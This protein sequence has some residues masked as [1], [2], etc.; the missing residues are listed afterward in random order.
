M[1]R[2][3][4]LRQVTITL[5]RKAN[6]WARE[7]AV[8]LVQMAF[9]FYDI[10]IRMEGPTYVVILSIMYVGGGSVNLMRERHECSSIL[11]YIRL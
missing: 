4:S 6:I 11:W 7:S 1:L 5:L 2:G 10:P 9:F 3:S 8:R